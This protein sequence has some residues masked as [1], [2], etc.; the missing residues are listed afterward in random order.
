[1][2]QSDDTGVYHMDHIKRIVWYVGIAAIV[3]DAAVRCAEYSDSQV[4]TAPV[5]AIVHEELE[6][7]LQ[8]VVDRAY[9]AGFRAGIE[10]ARGE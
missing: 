3:V 4:R 2:Y 9:Q 10:E 8:A 1:M 6:R 5:D 7:A